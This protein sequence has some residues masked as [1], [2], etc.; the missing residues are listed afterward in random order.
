MKCVPVMLG[1]HAVELY[2]QKLAWIPGLGLLCASDLHFEKG[3]FFRRFGSLLP[4]YDT[5]ETL[6]MLEEAVALFKPDIFVALGDSFHDVQAGGRL[7]V[8]S[9]KS[10]LGLVGGVKRWVWITG[11]HDPDIA[12]HIPGERW[13]ELCVE[14]VWFRHQLEEDDAVE[15][16]GHYHPKTSVRLRGARIGAACFVQRGGKLIMPAYGHYTGGLHVD[17]VAFLAVMPKKGR[18]VFMAYRGKVYEL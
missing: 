17:D 10:L 1:G 4:P 11:N 9:E 12:G 6:A 5:Q 8:E 14:G 16:S 2:G 15:I 3:S 13:G 7:R 18:R